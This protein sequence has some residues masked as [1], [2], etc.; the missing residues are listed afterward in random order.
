RR[1]DQLQR[2]AAAGR[3]RRPGQTRF[4]AHFVDDEIGR[5]IG[6]GLEQGERLAI[7]IEAAV[8]LGEGRRRVRA[9]DSGVGRAVL[10]QNE[11]LTS[12]QNASLRELVVQSVDAPAGEI[13]SEGAVVQN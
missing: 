7:G 6:A 11:N 10:R 13:E 3:I 1:I 9:V 5:T 4:V 12:G 2:C 8:E